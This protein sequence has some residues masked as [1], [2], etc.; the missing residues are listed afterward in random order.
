MLIQPL[1]ESVTQWVGKQPDAHQTGAVNSPL[2][3]HHG[4]FYFRL[5]VCLDPEIWEMQVLVG[6]GESKFGLGLTGRKHYVTSDNSLYSQC[7]W[8]MHM[9]SS[10]WWIKPLVWLVPHHSLGQFWSNERRAHLLNFELQTLHATR[11]C[12]CG[13]CFLCNHPSFMYYNK[14]STSGPQ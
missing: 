1:G 8:A 2:V 3:P 4:A 6:E 7:W 5:N 10:H 11:S 14:G 9:Q 13:L 12:D